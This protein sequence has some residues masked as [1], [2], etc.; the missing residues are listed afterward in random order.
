MAFAVAPAERWARQPQQ[1][2]PVDSGHP[3]ARDLRFLISF[4]PNAPYDHVSGTLGTPSGGPSIETMRGGARAAKLDSAGSDFYSFAHRPEWEILSAITLAWRGVIASGS[5]YRHFA[6]KHSSSGGSFNPFDFR[7]DNSA[8]PKPTIVRATGGASTGNYESTTA[9]TVGAISTVEVTQGAFVSDVPSFYVNGLLT[10]TT[11]LSGGSAAPPAGTG[12]PIRVGRRT[13]GAVQMDGY[14]EYLA[15]WGR[16]L[17]ATELAEFR[18]RPYALIK[19]TPRRVYF[20]T[21]G[22]GPSFQ[23]AWAARSNAVIQGALHA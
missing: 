14:T 15:G 17:T 5:N 13:D 19:Q 2:L 8:A 10:G 18:A 23:A 11:T 21:A 16:I 22:A 6:G 12:D 7:T 1:G 4:G 3:L 9:L 20:I